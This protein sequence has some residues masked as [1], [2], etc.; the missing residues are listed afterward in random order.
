MR[1][2]LLRETQNGIAANAS[3]QLRRQSIRAGPQGVTD[4]TAGPR[5]PAWGDGYQAAMINYRF[6]AHA[7]LSTDETVDR[8]R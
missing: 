2:S 1:E 5:H 7:V 8:M 4:A 3:P 6:L